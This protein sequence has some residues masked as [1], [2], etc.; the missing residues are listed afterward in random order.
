MVTLHSM[1]WRSSRRAV[2]RVPEGEAAKRIQQALESA[3]PGAL[4]M[5]MAWQKN[6][7][8]ELLG[9]VDTSHL[10]IARY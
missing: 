4:W 2:L 8:K 5:L 3:H 7:S 6:P 1:I 9:A 10:L